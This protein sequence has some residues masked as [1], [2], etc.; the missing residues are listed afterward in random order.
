MIQA[1]T[2][3]R[4]RKR[5]AAEAISRFGNRTD[6]GGGLWAGGSCSVPN[7]NVVVAA[8]SDEGSVHGTSL[9]A[10]ASPKGSPGSCLVASMLTFVALVLL[11]I[12]ALEF[13]DL[14]VFPTGILALPLDLVLSFSADSAASALASSFTDCR[15]PGAR[16]PAL[17]WTMPCTS[18]KIS[19]TCS[20]T[21]TPAYR[22]RRSPS[23][24][25]ARAFRRA[26]SKA[27]PF[28]F[29]CRSTCRVSL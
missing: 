21:S 12:L 25:T 3:P 10:S 20:F 23:A 22:A 24:Q 15:T 28:N 5:H 4:I 11:S 1:S 29:I 9:T 26:S 2:L 14:V 17:L 8:V 19:A 6:L 7:S 18:L 16:M 27:T 13:V